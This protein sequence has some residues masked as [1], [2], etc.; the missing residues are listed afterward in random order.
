MWLNIESID[1]ILQSLVDMQLSGMY[2][3][4]SLIQ[5]NHLHD[6]TSAIGTGF[7]YHRSLSIHHMKSS[8]TMMRISVDY[9]SGFQY[10]LLDSRNHF[11]KTEF[12]TS[13]HRHMTQSTRKMDSSLTRMDMV[14]KNI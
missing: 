8:L 3:I 14:Q 12:L 13:I 2:V 6:Y 9:T 4:Q 7:Q 11:Y 5:N 10:H 1:P